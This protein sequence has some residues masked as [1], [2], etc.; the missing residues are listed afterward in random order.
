AWEVTE[1]RLMGA[2]IEVEGDADDPRPRLGQAFALRQFLALPGPPTTPLA[3]RYSFGVALC[4]GYKASS[5]ELICLSE[6]ELAPVVTPISDIEVLLSDLH[7][8]LNQ[9]GP[10]GLGLSPDQL[11][12]LTPDMLPS[13]LQNIDRLPLFG[14]LCVD[15]QVERV[16]GKSALRDPPSQLYR[17]VN[18]QGAAF[19]DVS[20][21]TLSVLLD[22][23]RPFDK[24][25]NPHFDCD[26]TAPDSPCAVGVPREGEQ[27]VG[28][29]FVLALPEPQ[30]GALRQV[31]PWPARAD[32]SSLPWEGCAQDPT[33]LQVRAGEKEHTIRARFDPSD[34][35]AYAQQIQQNG[36]EIL[37]DRRESLLLSATISTKGGKL[38]R[39]ES[40]LD[41]T[42]ADAQAE[43]SVGYTP[44]SPPNKGAAPE[45]QI[46]ENGRLVRF[47]FTLRDQRGG[48]D[49]T[50][51][52]LCLMPAA[53]QE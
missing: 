52:E 21:F 13:Q 8:D 53:P 34:R 37:R 18:N 28:G 30:R 46:P 38:A 10:A 41:D 51:R 35:E 1:P 47:S 7:F 24:N 29:A 39:Y 6:Q 40:L 31:L 23:G 2:R 32:A 14:A 16:P 20:T 4:L 25:Q 33:L 43:I 5:G 15:G 17:C 42:V 27:Q 12:G 3:Q 36:Q 44:A 49:F 9:L 22:W 50:T 11:A 19:P 26:P 45:D 48:V